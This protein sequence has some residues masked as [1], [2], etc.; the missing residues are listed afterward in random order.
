[1]GTAYFKFNLRLILNFFRVLIGEGQGLL[2]LCYHGLLPSY[3][4]HIKRIPIYKQ[5]LIATN[6]ELYILLLFII[7]KTAT[8]SELFGR[9]ATFINCF[10]IFFS[11]FSQVHTAILALHR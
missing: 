8:N 5:A 10:L 4:E 6:S 2:K 11:I 9:R 3:D 7:K 1:M